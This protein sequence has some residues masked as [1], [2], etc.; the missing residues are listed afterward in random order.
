MRLRY[1]WP[2]ASRDWTVARPSWS[3]QVSCP[4]STSWGD[5]VFTAVVGCR[6]L[7][8]DSIFRLYTVPLWW[9]SNHDTY[10][11]H[12]RFITRR[13]RKSCRLEDLGGGVPW[14][15]L[16]LISSDQSLQLSN[17]LPLLPMYGSVPY[18]S[19]VRAA[20]MRRQPWQPHTNTMQLAV[21]RETRVGKRGEFPNGAEF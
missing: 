16:S 17:S 6:V 15:Q 1:F 12:R 20:S 18:T 8:Q 7:V 2:P 21:H 11:P 19:T 4:M 14:Q 9:S 10:R 3:H 13:R 5:E